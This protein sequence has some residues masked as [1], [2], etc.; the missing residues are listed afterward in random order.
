MPKKDVEQPGR[1]YR[2]LAQL[3]RGGM[4][5]ILLAVRFGPGGFR[6]LF[7]IKQLRRDLKNKA[8]PPMFMHEA[9]LAALLSH[10]N[11]VQAHEVVQSPEDFYLEMEYLEG[12]TLARLVRRVNRAQFPLELH[13]FILTELLAGLHHAHELKDL[14]GNTLEVVH[15]DVSPGNLFLTYDGQ[16]KLLDFG[17]AKSAES[18]ESLRSGQIKGK[19]G[20]MSPEQANATFVDRRSDIFSVGVMLWEAVACQPFVPRG[21]LPKTSLQERRAGNVR[22]LESVCPSVDLQLLAIVQKALA[23]EPKQRFQTA[24]E[25]R[26]ELLAYLRGMSK[27]SGREQIG[28]IVSSVFHKERSELESTIA[29][30]ISSGESASEPLIAHTLP[31][32]GRGA[33]GTGADTEQSFHPTLPPVQPPAHPSRAWKFAGIAAM[34]TLGCVLTYLVVGRKDEPVPAPALAPALAS[35]QAPVQ[36]PTPTP[37]PAPLTTKPKAVKKEQNVQLVV[38][39]RPPSAKV[40][41]DDERLGR[42][43][44]KLTRAL[45]QRDQELKVRL[46]GYKAFRRTV[47][48]NRDLHIE[49]VLEAKPEASKLRAS[50]RVKFQADEVAQQQPL[51]IQDKPQVPA[52]EPPARKPKVQ[53]GDELHRATKRRSRAIDEENPYQ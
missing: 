30:M 35:S 46:N 12:Q 23:F 47:R 51:S 41:L 52:Q 18:T 13:L 43:S 32:I 14:E 7:V 22:P 27:Q 6:K 21:E 42:G 36:P 9:R 8:Y 25:L 26:D 16:V 4:A 40:F 38:N 39:V 45:V 34:L 19:V 33:Y 15:R 31:G 11:V 48:L 20:Y 50:K 37:R 49:V 29:R 3:G 53:A 10:P 1:D 24:L 44:V 28:V 5:T 2:I 17:I